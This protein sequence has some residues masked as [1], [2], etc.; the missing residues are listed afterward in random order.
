MLVS[1]A[2][3]P[4]LGDNERAGA[5]GGAGR[6]AEC[7]SDEA[8]SLKR[9]DPEALRIVANMKTLKPVY[10]VLA[11]MVAITLIVAVVGWSVTRVD[12][13]GRGEHGARAGVTTATDPSLDPPVDYM[14]IRAEPLPL[15][16][17]GWSGSEPG[18]IGEAQASGLEEGT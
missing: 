15:H 13:D 1:G 4:G 11:T 9:Q 12:I 16:G 14:R 2:A 8:L 7:N 5:L 3:R 18:W 17:G 6:H 10:M